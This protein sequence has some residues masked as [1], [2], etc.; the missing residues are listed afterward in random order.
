VAVP[1]GETLAI[2]GLEERSRATTD[3]KVPLFGD[4]PLIGYAFKNKNSS[5]VRTTLL[6]FI[7][8]E[9]VRTDDAVALAPLPECHHRA[10]KGS[11]T[12]TLKDVDLSLNGLPSDIEALQKC[13]TGSNKDAILNRLGLIEVELSLMDVRLGELRLSEHP[14]GSEANLVARVREQLDAARTAVSA[15]HAE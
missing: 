1:V 2:A 6:A 12:E 8:P 5:T 11:D 15:V 9:L 14:T 10:F 4:I 3:S 7:T 13:A